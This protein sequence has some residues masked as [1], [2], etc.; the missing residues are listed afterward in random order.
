MATQHRPLVLIDGLWQQLPVGDVVAQ[1]TIEELE[2]SYAQRTDFVG[3][4]IIYKGWA[5]V[6][7]IESSSTWRIQKIEFVGVDEDIVI[8]WAEG[9]NNFDNVWNNRLIYTYS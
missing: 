5:A 3:D 8:T 2:M 7:E 1:D 9:N 6:G 4:T